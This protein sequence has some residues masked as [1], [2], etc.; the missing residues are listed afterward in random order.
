MVIGDLFCYKV[1]KYHS[2]PSRL[3]QPLVTLTSPQCITHV[4]LASLNINRVFFATVKK[5]EGLEWSVDHEN[6][7]GVEMTFMM[8]I[9]KYQY[10]DIY[11]TAYE[12]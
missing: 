6:I 4:F 9:T 1:C 12:V 2:H 10:F 11:E 5:Y 8:L 3:R 7:W